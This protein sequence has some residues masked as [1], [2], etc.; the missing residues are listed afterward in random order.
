MTA[1]YAIDEKSDHFISLR[2]VV[3]ETMVRYSNSRLTAIVAIDIS[4]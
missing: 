2:N 3:N 1:S 4:G